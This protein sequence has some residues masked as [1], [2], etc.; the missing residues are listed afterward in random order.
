MK[1]VIIAE[2]VSKKYSRN[3]NA[4]LSYGARD[5]LR[6]V[7][8]RSPSLEL[9]KDE[10]LAVNDVSFALNPGDSLGLIGR[11]GS[12]KTT[13][14]RMLNGLIKPDGGRIMI[15]GRVQALI[16]LGTGF[17]PKLNG[18]ENIYNAAALMGLSRRQA[19]SVFDEIVDFSELAEVIDSPVET[20]SSGMYARLGFSVSVHLRPEILLIDEI[21]A[22]GDAGFQNKCFIKM[23]QMKQQGVTIVLVSHSHTQITQ[24]CDQALWIHGG[25]RLKLGPARQVV[26]DYQAFLGEQE[27]RQVAELARLSTET[28]ARSR[29][30]ENDSMYGAIYDEE[31]RVEAIGVDF[32]VDGHPAQILR[33][34][35]PLTIRY[36]FTLKGRVEGLNVTLGFYRKDGQHMT[37]ISTLNGDLLASIHEG[38]VECEVTIPDLNL[39]PGRYVL[40]MPIHEGHAYLWRGVVREF[41]VVGSPRMSW[42]LI[43]LKYHDRILAGAAA[44][45]PGVYSSSAADHHAP[46]L[47]FV[48]E[49]QLGPELSPFAAPAGSGSDAAPSA[50]A[51]IAGTYG[52]DVQP[53]DAAVEP[54]D[55][56]EG[57]WCL[58]VRSAGANR[59]GISHPAR[60]F[61]LEGGR[62]YLIRCR[63]WCAGSQ[64]GFMLGVKHED[65]GY[66]WSVDPL[67]GA[68][69][70]TNVERQWIDFSG[71]LTIPE[72]G[73]GRCQFWI[74]HWEK[75][76]LTWYVAAL[77]IREHPAIAAA[78]SVLAPGAKK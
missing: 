78:H 48:D 18:R 40:V 72:Q 19:G 41:T 61:T 30:N 6:E 15:E 20:Y 9:R 14:L 36:G 2:N 65:L 33:I 11:N 75:E 60:L 26:Q 45:P 35:E 37:A 32:L 52:A 55:P 74:L 17:N 73:D 39:A 34:H 22:V 28:A 1:P 12:G 54:A 71:L 49:R 27:A 38:R 57:R 66:L 76:R 5:L 3:A 13:L 24:L 42:G 77:S 56:V 53:V 7:F 29:R 70:F 58:R 16:A 10:F 46:P 67:T 4:H 50:L 25:R 59:S 47:S 23:H 21:L 43:D 68:T 63:V 69:R 8:G 44:A 31:D 62:S 64:P 51:D